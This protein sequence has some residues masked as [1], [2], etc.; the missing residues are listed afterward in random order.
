MFF[1]LT[2]NVLCVSNTLD[3]LD[4]FRLIRHKKRRGSHALSKIVSQ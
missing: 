2:Q 3:Q 1:C 4:Q